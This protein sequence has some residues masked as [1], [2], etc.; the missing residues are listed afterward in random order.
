MSSL[1]QEKCAH[2]MSEFVEILR[3]TLRHDYYSSGETRDFE[4]APL[5]GTQALFKG[6][7]LQW[8]QDGAAFRLFTEAKQTGK[9]AEGKPIFTPTMDLAALTPLAFGLM[10]TNSGFLSA[11]DL[12]ETKAAHRAARSQD[13]QTDRLWFPRVPSYCFAID[14]LD[15]LLKERTV[16]DFFGSV[17]V[18]LK[19]SAPNV[20]VE[21][22]LADANGTAV[23]AKQY[24]ALPRSD[25]EREEVD[26]V[27][28]IEPDQNGWLTASFPIDDVPAGLY[29]LTTDI[30]GQDPVDILVRDTL[31]NPFFR[32]VWLTF[33]QGGFQNNDGT[34][35][36]SHQFDV[37]FK[38][39][40]RVW[41]YHITLGEKSKGKT[42]AIEHKPPN[43]EPK[44]AFK[45]PVREVEAPALTLKVETETP[46]AF[47][48]QPRA[49]IQLI[50]VLAAPDP[51]A[52]A[53]PAA[54]DDD[55]NNK[56]LIANLPS[57]N[58]AEPS[59]EVFVH[60]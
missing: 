7:R 26:G 34:L 58:P 50:E 11:T 39:A 42:L 60:V 29:S 4:I 43:G 6:H 14:P 54:G 28:P 19:T 25:A 15:E 55:T 27:S 1:T 32:T 18:R 48:E 44:I 13:Q 59:A 41:T 12:P 33:G 23:R 30:D 35:K 45:A 22:T 3:L 49:A 31:A 37:A 5:P 16:F 17:P 20:L 56:P 53:A 21:V 9:D 8:R 40:A 51:A 46:V 57:P 36:P 24:Q 38:A 47:R 10:L 52:P 2:F